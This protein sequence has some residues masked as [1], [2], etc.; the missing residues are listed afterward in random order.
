MAW[1]LNGNSNTNPPSNFLGTSDNKPLVI[2]TNGTEAI[3]IRP[4]GNVGIGTTNPDTKLHV[5]GPGVSHAVKWSTMRQ[6]DDVLFHEDHV[7]RPDIQNSGSQRLGE[8]S[9]R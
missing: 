5:R 6:L 1:E 4:S 2:K 9:N 7:H 8:S 3:R